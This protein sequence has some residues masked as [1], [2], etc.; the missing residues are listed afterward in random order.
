MFNQ[1]KLYLI[2]AFSLVVGILYT[3]LRIKTNKLEEVEDELKFKD[4]EIETNKA[5]QDTTTDTQ[6]DFDKKEAQGDSGNLS[7]SML[8]LLHTLRKDRDSS[9]PS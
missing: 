2:G 5:V 6:K 4:A 3:L 1:F 9:T 7:P 8:G